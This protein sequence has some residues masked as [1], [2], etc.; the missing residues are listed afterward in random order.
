MN[1]KHVFFDLDHTLWDFDKNSKL[2]F[3][4]VFTKL[5]IPI[6]INRFLEVYIPINLN[7]WR[8]F[9]EEKVSKSKLRYGRLKDSFNALE[10]DISDDIINEIADL[11]IEYL[12]NYNYLIEGTL[13]LLD[14]LKSKYQMHI[15]T[16]GFD[17]VQ[18]LKI[19]KSGLNSY[20]DKIITS[21]SV[22]VK[23]PNS[24]IF[25]FAIQQA[26]TN[27]QESIMIG[28]SYEA[29]VLGALEFGMMAI[30]CNFKAAENKIGGMLSVNS[31]KQIKGYL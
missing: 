10:Y 17:E 7:Y 18:H 14:Y 24:R 9:R 23:K 13:D 26:S 19:K 20:F 3:Q 2:T 16:N 4:E 22:G 30:H 31:L 21:E 1:I 28:D 29:D 6:E 11:Y 5:E 8:L 15:I 25:E 27:P 12:P